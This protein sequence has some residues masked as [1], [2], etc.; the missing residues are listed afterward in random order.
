M[1]KLSTDE[2]K[3]IARLANIEITDNEL[4]D[5]THKLA[6]V[7]EF[8]EQLQVEDTTNIIPTS[9]VTG[10][11]DVLREDKVVESSVSPE[12]LLKEAPAHQDGQIIVKRVLT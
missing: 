7:L 5:A 6:S 3:R 12:V 11:V 10:L 2:A 4:G 1:T 9:Q 8:V